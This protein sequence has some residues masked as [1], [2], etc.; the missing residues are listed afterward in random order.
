M[1]SSKATV[2]ELHTDA[3]AVGPCYFRPKMRE[4]LGAYCASKKNNKTE[5]RYHSSKLELLCIVW[6]VNKLRQ[7]V[8]RRLVHNFY[9]LPGFSLSEFAQIDE[10]TGVTLG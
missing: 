8:I 9:W 10:Y 2:I 1:F 7:F 6:A 5:K 3:S 4:N